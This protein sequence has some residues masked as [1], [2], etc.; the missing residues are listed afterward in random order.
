MAK[1]SK[2]KTKKYLKIF[3]LNNFI[4]L[5]LFNLIQKL[6]SNLSFLQNLLSKD[7]KMIQIIRYVL[8]YMNPLKLLIG[9]V[10]KSFK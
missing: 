2:M 8:V 1:F 6:I 9:F 5:L 10:I 3:V 7:L 4:W